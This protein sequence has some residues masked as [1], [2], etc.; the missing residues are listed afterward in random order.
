[1]L[2]TPIPAPRCDTAEPSVAMLV[3]PDVAALSADPD[4]AQQDTYPAWCP[5][6]LTLTAATALTI[7]VIDEDDVTHSIIVP[8][9]SPLVITRPIRTIDE[10]A[11]GAVQV[12]AEWFDPTGNNAWNT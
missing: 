2:R 3:I 10:S 5:Q 12:I 1:M 8:A 7:V 11:S 6:K 9:A 4:L